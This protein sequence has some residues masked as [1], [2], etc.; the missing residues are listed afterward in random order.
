MCLALCLAA[1]HLFLQ[2]TSFKLTSLLTDIFNRIFVSYDFPDSW[3]TSV[4]CPIFKAGN[5]QDPSCYRPISLIPAMSKKFSSVLGN[6]L[7]E[8]AE[9]VLSPAQTGFRKG[10]STLDNIF[11]LNNIISVVLSK[12]RG[13][14]YCAFI[15]FKAAFDSV[16]RQ[17][18]FKKLYSIG[19]NGN[20]LKILISMYKNVKARVRLSNGLT[21]EF[22]C[23]NGLKQ[24][25]VLSPLLFFLV[26]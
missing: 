1:K 25:C 5:E 20:F 7:R 21:D 11:I 3:N 14:L 22:S 16:D 12:R 17:L 4:I 6:R 26:Y 23:S 9:N 19:V 10:Y 24:G 13:K 2:C 18:L 8:W 15:D